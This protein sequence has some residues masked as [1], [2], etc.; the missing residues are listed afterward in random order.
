M[1]LLNTAITYNN[2]ASDIIL[3][4]TVNNNNLIFAT[5]LTDGNYNGLVQT[6]D[7]AIVYGNGISGNPSENTKGFVIAL[8]SNTS[9]GLRLYKDG[10]VT[11]LSFN[12]VSDYRFKDNV[13]YLDETYTCDDLKPIKY[14]NT[15]NNKECLGFLAHEVQSIYPCLVEGEKDLVEND[16]PVY[17]NLDYTGIIPVLVN[18]IKML[19]AELDELIDELLILKNSS[20]IVGP[21]I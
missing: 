15:K 20:G 17:Q 4:N 7:I 9:I 10:T 14:I 5:A 3:S 6:G 8:H 16:R 12:T 21:F 11:A 2:S 18:E 1:S 19:N 13:E